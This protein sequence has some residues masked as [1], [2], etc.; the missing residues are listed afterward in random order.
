M[1]E[2]PPERLNHTGAGRRASFYK[3]PLLVAGVLSACHR[4]LSPEA[5]RKYDIQIAGELVGSVVDRMKT[6]PPATPDP[7]REGR[8]TVAFPVGNEQI[9][10]ISD[11][12]I[13]MVESGYNSLSVDKRPHASRVLSVTRKDERT[14]LVK[15]E[16]FSDPSLKK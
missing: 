5:Q 9:S 4:A 6:P 3:I 12:A 16:F 13:G 14:C 2:S 11:T 15:L 7:E 10:S 8:F 1:A